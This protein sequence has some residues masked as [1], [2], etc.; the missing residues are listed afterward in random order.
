MVMVVGS[1]SALARRRTDQAESVSRLGSARL[2]FATPAVGSQE[3]SDAAGGPAG[4]VHDLPVPEAH[5]R[6]PGHRRVQ[7]PVQVGI[8]LLDRVVE[9]A[10]VQLQV[11]LLIGHVSVD[12]TQGR[13]RPLLPATD[14]QPVRS[15]DLHQV[16]MLEHRELPARR[17]PAHWR[18][19]PD[20]HSAHDR[21]ASERV[22]LRL[23]AARRTHRPARRS[24]PALTPHP[25][26]RPA[27]LRRSGAG[28]GRGSTESSPPGAACDVPVRRHG[29]APGAPQRSPP[30]WPVPDPTPGPLCGPQ[31]RVPTEGG[32]PGVQ[33]AGPRPY[34]PRQRSRVVDVHARV[35]RRP[36]T[37]AH[38]P[39]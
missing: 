13:R 35:H 8:A 38:Q 9:Q 18:G 22:E 29:P 25:R 24:H 37:T 39:T 5:R 6:T 33:D 17:H 14:R 7:V 27:L 15:L 3:E 16:R 1:R 21:R 31:R 32:R 12:H 26:P 2:R 23:F 28:A 36:H 11:Q 20:A 19:T 4:P 34:Q 10:P 30:G